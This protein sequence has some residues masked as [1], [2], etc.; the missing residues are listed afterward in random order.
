MNF[1]PLVPVFLAIFLCAAPLWAQRLAYVFGR[2]FDPSGASVPEAAITVV[3]QE[4]GF[5]HTT[6]S[7]PDGA[8]MV[9]SLEPGLYKVTVRKDGFIGM[10]RFDVK[11]TALAPAHADFSLKVGAVQETITVEGTAPLL[12]QEESSIG[13]RVFHEDIQRIPVNGRGILGL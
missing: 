9:A 5:R 4:N 8:Y 2:I 12:S 13:L 7:G 1:G 3:D 6:Q 11:V 10:M